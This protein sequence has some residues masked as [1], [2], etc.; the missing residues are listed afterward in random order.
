ML[1]RSRLAQLVLHPRDRLF[2]VRVDHVL[3][4]NGVGGVGVDHG[5]V[6]SVPP[7]RPDPPQPHDSGVFLIFLRR[8]HCYLLERY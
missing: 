6:V 5:D 8:Q 2:E 7:P 1:L 3:V 4:L